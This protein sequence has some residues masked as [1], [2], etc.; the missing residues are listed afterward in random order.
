MRN[1]LS[2]YLYLV[3][4]STIDVTCMYILSYYVHQPKIKRSVIL[5]KNQRTYS[6]N[7]Q[8]HSDDQT[9]ETNGAPED[10][11]DEY[12]DEEGGVGGV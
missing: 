1:F 9:E 6:V 12:L 8:E 10:F 5:K 3:S 2:Y 4:V 7:Y 11:H